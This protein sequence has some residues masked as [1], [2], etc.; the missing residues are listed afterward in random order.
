M[1]K[2][3]KDIAVL[4]HGSISSEVT[5][6]LEALPQPIM[7][8]SVPMIQPLDFSD[9]E[10]KLKGIHTI[11]T[12]EEHFVDGGLGTVIA[13]WI[14]K[15]G[16]SFKLTKLGVANEFLHQIKNTSGM[17][18]FYG[19]SSSHIREVVMAGLNNG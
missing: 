15:K 12:V 13:E 9:L 10:N 1:V 18:D 11:I 4:F 8:F 3:G 14:L 16:L 6:A 17:R 5:V 7:A 2:E 19:I